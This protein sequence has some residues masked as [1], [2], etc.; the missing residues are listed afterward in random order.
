[1]QQ[2]AIL[3]P[4]LLVV[5][6]GAGSQWVGNLLGGK[7]R[8]LV[9]GAKMRD[10]HGRVVHASADGVSF[11]LLFTFAV[12][13]NTAGAWSRASRTAKVQELVRAAVLRRPLPNAPPGSARGPGEAA[14]QLE[15]DYLVESSDATFVH[16][17]RPSD[18]VPAA[19]YPSYLHLLRL[20]RDAVDALN[21]TPIPR[22]RGR[23]TSTDGAWFVA[24]NPASYWPDPTSSSPRIRARLVDDRIVPLTALLR[25]RVLADLRRRGR[26]YP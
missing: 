1:V 25:D 2:L 21:A 6:G 4:R 19:G 12:S 23:R 10:L 5:S 7:A 8:E 20:R 26:P 17:G 11:D 13:K 15:A 22:G 14:P 24:R 16:E 18:G 9:R 3:R